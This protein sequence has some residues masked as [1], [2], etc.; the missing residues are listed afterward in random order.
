M[1]ETKWT[2]KEEVKIDKKSI[3]SEICERQKVALSFKKRQ[4]LRVSSAEASTPIL[5]GFCLVPSPQHRSLAQVLHEEALLEHNS[6]FHWTVSV[7]SA[8]LFS[9]K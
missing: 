9:F 5:E 6:C 2:E 3:G 1:T 8:F 4:N 7:L